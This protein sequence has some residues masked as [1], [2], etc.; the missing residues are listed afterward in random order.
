MT[1]A[2]STSAVTD[3][4]P[5]EATGPA[6]DSSSLPARAS[7]DAAAT[8]SPAQGS[9]PGA[10]A[11]SPES[12]ADSPGAD[13][14][15]RLCGPDERGGTLDLRA[16]V[17][18][19]KRM[20]DEAR[21]DEWAATLLEKL[22]QQPEDTAAL[23][24]LLL[25]GLSHPNLRERNHDAF[26]GEGRRLAILWERSQQPARAHELLDLL[27]RTFPGERV[28]ETELASL[29]RRSGQLERLVQ[30]HV[31]HAE[32]AAAQGRRREAINWL[33][34]ALTLDGSR[35]DL[36]RMI[37]DLQYAESSR[38]HWGKIIATISVASAAL[39]GAAALVQ[40]ERGLHAQYA[41]IPEAAKHDKIGLVARLAAIEDMI[42][43]NWFWTGLYE[44]GLERAQLRAQLA[45][46]DL[47]E[48]LRRD[49]R[50]AGDERTLMEVDLMI[51][52]TRGLVAAGQFQEALAQI[53]LALALA[54]AEWAARARAQ[55]D[56]EAILHWIGQSGPGSTA[57]TPA[58]ENATSEAPASSANE[59]GNSPR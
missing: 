20:A 1:N 37:R 22:D 42:A 51:G 21:A 24:A 31:Q 30:R 25:L 41:E 12:S 13:L 50:R 46:L 9:S 48:E 32:Q 33:R 56:R 40:R 8:D 17:E 2:E 45:R 59:L 29:M 36:A 35:R 14:I 49:E 44:A 39:L 23:E 16:K 58:Q 43:R 52:R 53:D 55:A 54:P 4:T 38:I 27:S 3:S 47:A 28:L 5:A 34:E 19:A 6:P 57:R 11:D 18:R 15:A 10:K 7:D 26:I